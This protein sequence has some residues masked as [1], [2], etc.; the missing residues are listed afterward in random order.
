[1]A[2]KNIGK[3]I[4]VRVYS[5]SIQS[6]SYL[7]NSSKGKQQRVGR[8]FRMHANHQEII[9]TLEAGEIGAVVGLNDT[10][11]GDTLCSQEDPITLESI[12]FPA[13]VISIAVSP[14]SRADRDKL[15]AAL[16]KLAEEDPTF[17]V[18][19]DP[20]TND[21][22]ISG[23]GEL[24]LDIIVDRLRRE[25]KVEVDTGAPEVSYRETIT[26]TVEH[27]E[28]F[29]KQTGGH[30]QYAHVIFKLEPQEPGKGY[31]FVDEVKGGEKVFESGR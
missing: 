4:Y 5:G 26:K 24:H 23:M 18:R 22:I 31:E 20:E 13:P 19:V 11:T 2:D 12:E 17:T 3:L 15:M 10:V 6:G 1:M 27:E 14:K 21:T 16:I 28:R 9:E 29:K 7:Y 30:G 8:L 25:F